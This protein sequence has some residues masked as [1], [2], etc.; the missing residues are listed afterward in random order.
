LKQAEG[1]SEWEE[2]QQQQ[3]PEDNHGGIVFESEEG[4]SLTAA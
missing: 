3:H 2:Y 1:V 4:Q